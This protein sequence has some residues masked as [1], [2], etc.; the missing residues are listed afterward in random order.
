VGSL[1]GAGALLGVIAATACGGAAV[2]IDT[3]PAEPRYDLTITYW[4]QGKDGPSSTA[5]LS[6]DPTG[7][8]HPDP[9][10]ACAALDAHPEALHPVPADT[11]CTEIYG[12]DQVALVEG[13][14][15][16]AILNRTNGCEIARWDA[17]A[18]LLELSS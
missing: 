10:S 1:A 14:G 6:C 4:P 18:P 13:N 11:A 15:V 3:V 12:G 5:T 8:T 7:G 16:R 9:S 17:L 2:D